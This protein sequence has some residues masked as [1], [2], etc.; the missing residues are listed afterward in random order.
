MGNG[1][2]REV[3]KDDP[4]L[5]TVRGILR[6]GLTVEGLKQFIVAQGGSR[7]IVMMEWDK[8]W[9]FNKKVIDPIA[10]RYTAVACTDG[11][12][13]VTVVD[14]VREE[15]KEVPLHPKNADVGMKTIWYSKTVEIEEM[16]AKQMKMGDTVTFIN[17]G[18]MKICDIVKED[19]KITEIKARLDLEN[20]DYKKTL[21]VTW[22]AETK[23]GPKIP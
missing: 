5:P 11:P 3:T 12:V 23:R 15:S 1:F 20:K 16:D 21:K 4:R 10:P 8:I 14:A 13:R 18:N 6:R 22:I 17:W 19:N 9:S 2:I 7:A